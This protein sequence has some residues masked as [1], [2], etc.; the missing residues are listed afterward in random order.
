MKKQPSGRQIVLS[1]PSQ[2]NDLMAIK[3]SYNHHKKITWLLLDQEVR[4]GGDRRQI[5]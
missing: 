5:F 1:Q 2:E 4:K 3:L